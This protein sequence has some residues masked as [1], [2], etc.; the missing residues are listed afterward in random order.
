MHSLQARRALQLAC[1]SQC[2]LDPPAGRALGLQRQES[3][4]C[5]VGLRSK[6]FKLN[7]D[8]QSNRIPP[9]TRL[10]NEIA[11]LML[12]HPKARTTGH[13][14]TC[15]C[16]MGLRFKLVKMSPCVT[17][18][19]HMMEKALWPAGSTLPTSCG[20]CTGLPWHSGGTSLSAW[21][22]M[23]K[24]ILF[25]DAGH[26]ASHLRYSPLLKEFVSG[27]TS[28]LADKHPVSQPQT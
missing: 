4:N 23:H 5:R 13:E 15:F 9:A 20:R 8:A 19:A 14:N 22:T 16:N 18:P 28:Q 24:S 12:E 1:A 10:R 26:Q 25:D 21:H 27:S 6:H 17:C 11:R 2:T 7:R 3:G